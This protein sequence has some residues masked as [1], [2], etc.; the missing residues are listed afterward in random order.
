VLTLK[1][2]HSSYEK[3]KI[4]FYHLNNQEELRKYYLQSLSTFS[5]QI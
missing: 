5:A 4:L 3:K 2:L 1:N